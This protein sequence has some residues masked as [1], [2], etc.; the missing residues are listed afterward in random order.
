MVIWRLDSS[1]DVSKIVVNHSPP[2][3]WLKLKK[4]DDAMY[5]IYQ[6][7]RLATMKVDSTYL[8]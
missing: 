8:G 3:E 7:N 5:F 4:N 6:I 2:P 1:T